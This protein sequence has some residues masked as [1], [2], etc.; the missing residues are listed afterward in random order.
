MGWRRNA[1]EEEEEKRKRSCSSPSKIFCA[2]LPFRKSGDQGEEEEEG[3]GILLTPRLGEAEE[4]ENLD[5]RR[6]ESS[7]RTVPS[8]GPGYFSS[9]GEG[10]SRPMLTESPYKYSETDLAT[11]YRAR[12]ES[13]FVFSGFS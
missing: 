7:G 5:E 8:A 1:E 10:T 11:L 2:Y 3:S 6:R 12:E 4:E 9:R 13:V